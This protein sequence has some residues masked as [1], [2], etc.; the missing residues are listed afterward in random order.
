M[1]R[2]GSV[3][4]PRTS[5]EKQALMI[6]EICM[7]QHRTFECAR[8]SVEE[9][10]RGLECEHDRGNGCVECPFCNYTNPQIVNALDGQVV[11]RC[12]NKACRA[13]GPHC[14]T[15]ADAQEKWNAA[16]R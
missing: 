9:Y 15:V 13:A 10:L 11:V 8:A 14:D 1:L 2:E 5:I 3:M 7:T 4:N 6:A 12:S 16:K